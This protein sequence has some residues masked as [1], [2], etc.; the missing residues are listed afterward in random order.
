MTDAA[1]FG[2]TADFRGGVI[3]LVSTYFHVYE[4]WRYGGIGGEARCVV[5][6]NK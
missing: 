1:P 6:V 2:M 5:I 4:A 3:L